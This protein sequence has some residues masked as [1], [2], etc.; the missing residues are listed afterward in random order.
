MKSKQAQVQV[1]SKAGKVNLLNT[2]SPGRRLPNKILAVLAA[3]NGFT[4]VALGAFA[5]HGLER[6][7]ASELVPMWDTGVRYQ[8]FHVFATL[9]AVLIAD[10]YGTSSSVRRWAVIAGWCFVAG[11]VLFCGSLYTMTLAP[12]SWV[13]F[14]A[15]IGGILFLTGW[16]A[17]AWSLIVS[18]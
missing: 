12:Q 6:L 18:K 2:E 11:T 13:V 16:L 8:L 10:L 7:A 17:L 9:A 5:A 15:P 14:A 1:P 3:V 4:A